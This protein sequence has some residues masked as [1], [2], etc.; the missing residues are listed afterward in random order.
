MFSPIGQSSDSS[1][2]GFVMGSATGFSISYDSGTNTS[3][4]ITNHHFCNEFIENDRLVLVV[5]GS[6]MPR[7]NGPSENFSTGSVIK[8]DAGRDLCLVSAMG[9]FQPASLAG[10]SYRPTPTDPVTIV[11]GPSGTFPIIL[12]TYFSGYLNRREV[13]LEGLDENGIDFLF[14]SGLIYPGHSGSP[15]FNKSG[16]V[17]GVIFASLPSYGCIAIQIED[18]HNFLRK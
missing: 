11:G 17:I 5:E 8:S 3:F 1:I 14:I 18:L 9:F 2:S 12:D 13:H 6:N 10:K 16:Q 7:I 15:V 4:V